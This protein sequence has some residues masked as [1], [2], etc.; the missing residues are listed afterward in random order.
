MVVH[1]AVRDIHSLL[2]FTAFIFRILPPLLP[3]LFFLP[4]LWA[5]SLTSSPFPLA[6][7]HVPGDR[8]ELCP[9]ACSRSSKY[10]SASCVYYVLCKHGGFSSRMTTV[11]IWQRW[12]RLF[13]LWNQNR[14]ARRETTEWAQ[15]HLY[16][17][18]IYNDIVNVRVGCQSIIQFL[19]E[20]LPRNIISMSDVDIEALM[21]NKSIYCDMRSTKSNKH[22]IS[23]CVSQQT[24]LNVSISCS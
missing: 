14:R 4:F 11:R 1:N 5:P 15:S 23:L 3:Y 8:G 13:C 6:P 24:N 7:L 2:L 18:W 20:E 10:L 17:L 19:N 12:L 22:F 16:S 9:W 21:G